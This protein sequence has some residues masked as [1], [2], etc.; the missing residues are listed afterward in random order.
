MSI[1]I[2]SFLRKENETLVPIQEW[3]DLIT[4][5]EYLEGALELTINGSPLISPVMWDYV[6]ELWAYIITTLQKLVR[7]G[8]SHTY[9]PDQPIKLDMKKTSPGM[10]K[11]SISSRSGKFNNS[12]QAQEDQL[13]LQL[14]NEG[15]RFFLKMQELEPEDQ[16]QYESEIEQIKSFRSNYTNCGY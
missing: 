11:I 1:H 6:D 13:V 16:N 15:E 9:F 8:S 12:T 5:H 2:Q 14:L 7:D 4:D 3:D 10:V